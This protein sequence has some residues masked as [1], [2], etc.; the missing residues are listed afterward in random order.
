MP[1]HIG[2]NNESR[3]YENGGGNCDGI[4][5]YGGTTQTGQFSS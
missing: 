2:G 3:C 5:V 4:Q 1:A